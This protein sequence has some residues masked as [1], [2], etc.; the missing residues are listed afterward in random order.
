MSSYYLYFSGCWR[1]N[2]N[3]CSQNALLFLHQKENA[4]WKHTVNLHLLWNLFQVAVYEFCPKV[5]FL[6]SV[7]A[8]AELVHKSCYRCELHHGCRKRGKALWIL[9]ISPNK[10]AFL[11]SS[12][13]K[14]IP[15]L[16][17]T[18]RKILEKSPSG[19]PLEKILTTSMNST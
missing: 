12:G 3:G 17:V 14:Q 4:P 9:K 15:P 18:P 1:C 11:L 5:Y 8:F 13:K 2:A 19:S 6:S 10:V 7:T 16:L